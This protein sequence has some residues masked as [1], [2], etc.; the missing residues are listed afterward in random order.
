[1]EIQPG[2]TKVR[3]VRGL[4]E[5]KNILEDI[6]TDFEFDQVYLC[7]GWAR[8]M[9]STNKKPADARDV[10]LYCSSNDV[11]EKLKDFFLTRGLEVRY[12]NAISM[13]FN[14]VSDYK[15]RYFGSPVIQIIRPMKKGAIDTQGSL[16]NILSNFDFSVIRIGMDIA[17]QGVTKDGFNFMM[18][19]NDFTLDEMNQAIRIKNIHCPVSSM[20]RCL[21]YMRRK[22]TLR[23]IE[24]LKLF[25]DW[26][27]RDEEEYKNE[28]IRLASK[29]SLEQKE[30]D[31][32]EALIRVD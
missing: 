28:I 31:E 11:Y 1:M 24:M 2:W 16:E 23:L 10:D 21:K 17:K 30:I 27:E 20:Y 22:Y 6:T 14:K 5:I 15:H 8:Y 32:L 26:E 9:C 29:D 19:D 7:G 13:T 3:V 4:V 18:A 25:R 12:E